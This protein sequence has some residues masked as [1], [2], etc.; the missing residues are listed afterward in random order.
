MHLSLS[1]PN[2][3]RMVHKGSVRERTPHWPSYA[4]GL[5]REAK[6]A[7]EEA[8]PDFEPLI[9][10]AEGILDPYYRA[11]ALAWI[12]REAISAGEEGGLLFRGAI[13]AAEEVPQEWRRAEILLQIAAEMTKVG[14]GD[15][16]ALLAAVEGIG[17]AEEREG[18]QKA[19]IRRMAR[20]GIDLPVPPPEAHP[21]LPPSGPSPEQKRKL[22]RRATASPQEEAAITLSLL[23]TYAGEV[24]KDVHI[25]AIARAAPLC[26]AFDLNL[27]LLGFP[28]RDAEEVVV[29]VK[30]E[31]RLGEAGEYL[32][33]LHEEERL[34]VLDVP[35][36]PVLPGLGEI[37]VTTSHPDPR[38]RTEIETIV[39]RG[40]PFCVLMGL[41]SRG[42]PDRVLRSSKYHVELTG[43]DIPLETCTAMAVLVAKLDSSARNR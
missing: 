16:G 43:R 7:A 12:A 38:K 34:F 36:G 42:L 19:V 17:S 31:T 5:K 2:F 40:R 33:R 25:R 10:R 20:K 37:V 35:R 22:T 24:L 26:Y 18:T 21:Y 3:P 6:R 11:Q 27:C 13:E 30:G 32:Q 9:D 8:E 14:R 4:R 1:L 23:N 29:R 39:K 28:V 41:G 15:F